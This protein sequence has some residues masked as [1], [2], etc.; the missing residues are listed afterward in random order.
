MSDSIEARV[1]TIIAAELG[2]PPQN[3]RPETALRLGDLAVSALGAGTRWD[4]DDQ[5]ARQPRG[6]IGWEKLY[7]IAGALERTFGIG[8]DAQPI[9]TWVT[10]ADV[11][12]AI[13][14][15]LA[16]RAERADAPAPA[17]PIGRAAA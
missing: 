4:K 1:R 17:A 16:R 3:V 15:Q 9:D 5:L 14:R 7:A 2:V 10:V 13:E 8:L 11:V 6:P 12:L